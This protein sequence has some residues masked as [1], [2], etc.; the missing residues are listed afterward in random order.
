[1]AA[2]PTP[3]VVVMNSRSAPTVEGFSILGPDD[4]DFV[5]IGH[6]AELVIDGGETDGFSGGPD[7]YVKVLG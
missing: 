4:V 7:G 3:E 1:M 2:T 5:A 6:L